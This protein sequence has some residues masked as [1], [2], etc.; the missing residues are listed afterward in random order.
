[1]QH[2]GNTFTLRTAVIVTVASLVC[3]I[4]GTLLTIWGQ[5]FGTV[6]GGIFGLIGITG[7]AQA[8]IIALVARRR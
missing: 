3:L 5:Q 4:L 8:V 6:V 1:M 2:S 7:L